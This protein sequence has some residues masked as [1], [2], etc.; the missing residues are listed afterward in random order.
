M[1]KALEL[2]PW[3]AAQR[4]QAVVVNTMTTARLWP[5]VTT[6]REFDLPISNCMGKATPVGLGLALARPEQPVW[7][8]DGDG[9]LAM[10]LGVLLS[11][12]QAAP[13]NLMHFVFDDGAYTTVGGSPVPG[14]RVTDYAALALAAGYKAA[15]RI[16]TMEAVRSHLPAMLASTGPVCVHLVIESWDGVADYGPMTQAVMDQRLA[17]AA[18]KFWAV[19]K[20]LTGEGAGRRPA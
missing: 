12:A 20:T 9:S 16:D 3:L 17:A 7:V 19:R 8:F 6:K 18:D 2:L 10:N 15:R 5:A 4:G 1:L 14:A 11:V 13:H